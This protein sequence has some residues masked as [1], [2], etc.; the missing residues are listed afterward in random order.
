MPHCGIINRPFV[1]KFCHANAK[2]LLVF[3]SLRR[4]LRNPINSVLTRHGELVGK[5]ALGWTL[6]D[7]G[8]YP[9]AVLSDQPT[10]VVTGEL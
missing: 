2:D 9:G 1:A 5:A 10:A 3:G 8:T 7:L 6:Y 4:A